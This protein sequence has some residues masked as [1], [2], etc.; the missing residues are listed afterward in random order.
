M[1]CLNPFTPESDQC[2][3]SPATSQEIW[4]SRSMENLTLHSLLR[5]KVIKL[6]KFSLCRSYNCFLK[7]G[8]IHFLSLG[9]KGL[10]KNTHQRAISEMLALSQIIRKNALE[11][12]VHVTQK[13]HNFSYINPFIPESD[14]CQISPPAPPEISH[15]TVSRSWLFIAYSDERW[16]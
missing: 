4:H 11:I 14:Q 12:M 5:W 8:R 10:M 13:Q 9:A 16:F 15:H 1:Q 3:N 6:Y 7:F 2:Q